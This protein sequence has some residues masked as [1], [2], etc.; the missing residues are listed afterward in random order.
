MASGAG[1]AAAAPKRR[2]PKRKASSDDQDFQPTP[3]KQQSSPYI[4]VTKV[5]A[6]GHL[7][8]CTSKFPAGKAE[9]VTIHTK[10]LL[11]DQP[12]P[13]CCSVLSFCAVQ[14]DRPL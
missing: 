10:T 1:R 8:D 2:P 14:E 12:V 4:G 7:R 6:G 11:H 13:D 5:L 9:L 3:P